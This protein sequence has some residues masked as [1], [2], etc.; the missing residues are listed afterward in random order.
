[1]KAVECGLTPI[2]LNTVLLKGY[3]EDEL[4]D[5]ISFAEPLGGGDKVIVKFIKLV[6]VD[7]EFYSNFHYDL[8]LVE[9]KLMEKASSTYVREMQHRPQYTLPNGVKVEIVRPIYNVKFLMADDRVRI[10]CDRRFK[11]CLLLSDG[12]V[13][14]LQSTRGAALTKSWLPT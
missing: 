6:P 1:M 5:I 12:G 13:D 4:W 2:K 8:K 14:F 7:P 10:T 11:I 3:N 9:A